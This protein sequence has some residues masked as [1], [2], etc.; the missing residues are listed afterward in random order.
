MLDSASALLV[1]DAAPLALVHND[2]LDGGTGL[3]SYDTA[4]DFVQQLDDP[5][6][7]IRAM[8]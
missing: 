3:S 5:V 8:M 7:R 1:L 6:D 4:V 2:R